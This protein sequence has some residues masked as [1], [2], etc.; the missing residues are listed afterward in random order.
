MQE[1]DK[2]IIMEFERRIPGEVKS[3]LKRLIR[4]A[5]NR[6]RNERFRP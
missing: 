6:K 4:I 3:H 1:R 5:I 2:K